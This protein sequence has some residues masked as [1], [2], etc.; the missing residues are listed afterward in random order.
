LR[1]ASTDSGSAIVIDFRSAGA[2]P[3]RV[4]H[5]KRSAPRHPARATIESTAGLLACGS[6]PVTAF[7][8]SSQ[9][10]RGFQA[11]R[12]QLRGQL[13]SWNKR[14]A[15]HSLFRSLERETVDRGHYM[16][17]ARL[18]QRVG[19]SGNLSPVGCLGYSHCVVG[20]RAPREPTGNAVTGTHVGKPDAA[21]AP[22]TVGGDVPLGMP[23]GRK[24][25]EGERRR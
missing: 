7:P 3:A 14:P 15:P 25:R 8:G 6:L 12:L 21:A 13:R 22:A 10:R 20:S 19:F 17:G 2:S 23:L 16:A 24:A 4:R 5:D 18:C 9:W 1:P 11:R